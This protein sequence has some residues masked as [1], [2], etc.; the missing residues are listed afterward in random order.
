MLVVA[1]GDRGDGGVEI[2]NDGPFQ[3]LRLQSL[4]GPTAGGGAVI[5]EGTT[6]T[7]VG[8]G[9]LQQ[10]V[11]LLDRG[12]CTPKPQFEHPPHRTRQ[13]LAFQLALDRPAVELLHRAALLLQPGQQSGDLID[14][15]DGTAGEIAK[16]SIDLRRGRLGDPPCRL[17]ELPV[18][19]EAALVDEA[20]QLP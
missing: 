3:V 9:T 15:G 18:N 1:G 10:R 8:A 6:Y 2:C 20:A 13:A 7:I 12:L 5:A 17:G 11:D 4:A 16:L 14:P 19:A